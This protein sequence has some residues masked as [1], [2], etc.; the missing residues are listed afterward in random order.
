M[1]YNFRE[2]SLESRRVLHA[3][4][5]G[6]AQKSELA[7]YLEEK[8]M[9]GLIRR[10]IE[11]G[12]IEGHAIPEEEEHVEETATEEELLER[13]EELCSMVEYKRFLGL[14]RRLFEKNN[15]LHIKFDAYCAEIRMAI[16]LE[17][18]TELN[19][20][21]KKAEGVMELGV[22]WGR[23]NRFKLYKGMY[24]MMHKEYELGAQ[25]F[26][27]SLST[28]EGKE[29]ITYLDLVKY[30]IF[31]G[32]ISL[33]RGEIKKQLIESSEVCEVIRE[34]P[35]AQE[36]IRSFY[37]CMYGELFQ[38]L[39]C[40]GESLREDTYLGDRVDYFVYVVKVRAYSQLF[41]S[42]K[43]ISLMQMAGIFGVTPEYIHRDVESMI[44]R[45]DLH[46]KI[47]HQNMMIYNI[48]LAAPCTIN[49]QAEEISHAIQKAISPE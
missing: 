34:I 3:V 47:N 15:L 46:C 4:K 17:K 23:K 6:R 44:L 49:M 28:F 8:R 33:P 41:M 31:C 32:M 2:P 38:W 22:D 16:L 7:Q 42:Y 29:L 26:I 25:Q 20:A 11:L 18:E 27:E 19:V 13:A 37:E 10:Y 12:Y 36:M 40:F 35:G 39:L 30:S 9:F 1:E 43:A 5:E 24:S 45:G 21:M 48:P 14:T